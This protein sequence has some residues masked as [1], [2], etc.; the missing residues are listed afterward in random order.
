MRH[1][2]NISEASN[3]AI[4]GLGYLGTLGPGHAV[5]AAHMAQDLGVSEHHLAKVLQKLVQQGLLASTRGA[6]GGFFFEG[7][8]NDITLI[9]II[10]AVDGP[11]PAQGCLLGSPRCAPGQCKLSGLFGQVAE[12]VTRHLSEITLGMLVIPAANT[13]KSSK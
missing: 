13:R 3:L 7:N 11:I 9:S 2:L 6:K 1:L 5:S 4:H 8:P 10:E 12:L